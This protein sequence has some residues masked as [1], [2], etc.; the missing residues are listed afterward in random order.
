M[1]NENTKEKEPKKQTDVSK[2]SLFQRISFFRETVRPGGTAGLDWSDDGKVL[3]ISNSS[4][5]KGYTFVSEKKLKANVQPFLAQAGL[6]MSVS[7][8]NFTILPILDK[9]PQHYLVRGTMTLTDIDHETHQSYSAYGEG[10]SNDD[11]ATSSA[12]TTAFKQIWFNFLMIYDAGSDGDL[13]NSSAPFTQ[14]NQEQAKK[15]IESRQ[16]PINETKTVATDDKASSEGISPMQ[17][18]IM[19]NNLEKWRRAFEG[20]TISESDYNVIHMDYDSAISQNTKDSAAVFIRRHK[21]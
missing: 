2:M 11:K 17:K 4:G 18:K 21:V 16:D 7:F 19:S 9:K 14:V 10:S 8:D 20:G 12:Q 3:P 13:Q 1:T 15:E 5:F 6:E